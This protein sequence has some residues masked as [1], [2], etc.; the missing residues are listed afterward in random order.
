MTV[1][2][3][4]WGP[5]IFRAWLLSGGCADAFARTTSPPGISP[6]M[7]RST[8][9]PC[10]SEL[11]CAELGWHRYYPCWGL[12]ICLSQ[13]CLHLTPLS[14]GRNVSVL[15]S[16]EISQTCFPSGTQACLELCYYSSAMPDF[17]VYLVS[18]MFLQLQH[19]GDF[20]VTSL[21]LL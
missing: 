20:S 18:N 3:H 8:Q 2:L 21:L 16:A 15:V 5:E 19:R 11:C 13:P 17:F 7:C 6:R 4:L 14:L 10:N 12:A 9:I 1:F